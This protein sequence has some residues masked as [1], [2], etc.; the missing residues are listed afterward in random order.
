MNEQ[1]LNAYVPLVLWTTLGLMVRRWLPVWLP[2]RVGRS[3]YWVGIPLLIFSSA[4][5]T[6]FSAE[7]GIAP[8][9]SLGAVLLGLGLGQLAL[10][11]ISLRRRDQSAGHETRP[12]QGSLL[13]TSMLGNAGYLGLAIVPL[14][15]EPQYGSIPALYVVT[16]S[17][18][19]TYGVGVLVASR[20]GDRASLQWLTQ[21]KR[22]VLVPTLWAFVL[23][24]STQNLALPTVANYPIALAKL[25]T[26]PC[27]FA[28]MGIRLSEITRWRQL[29]LAFLPVIV[30]M[31]AVPLSIAGILTL[32]SVSSQTRLGLVLMAGMPSAFSCLILAEEYDL[33]RPV[34]SGAIA[35]STP[36]LLATLPFW[37]WWLG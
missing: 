27:A 3:L 11:A 22:L 29:Q 28:L 31:L 23:G 30:K 7:M 13:L 16:Q 36:C 21:L 37:L 35:L 1:L 18:V 10:L 25:V 5:R 33:E 15:L 26:A 19:G 20:Y 2:K 32:L 9:F 12:V 8:V 6:E 17:T 34:I 4:Q 24:F 14:L